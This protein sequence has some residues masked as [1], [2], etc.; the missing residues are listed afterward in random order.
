MKSETF[1][2]MPTTKLSTQ[3]SPPKMSI[4]YSFPWP[5]EK[6]FNEQKK[7]L[8]ITEEEED[9]TFFYDPEYGFGKEPNWKKARAIFYKGEKVRVFPHEFSVLKP[10]NMASYANGDEYCGLQG[11]LTQG[12][13]YHQRNVGWLELDNGYTFFVDREMYEAFCS[14]FEITPVPAVEFK[15][16]QEQSKSESK[17]IAIQKE[18]KVKKPKAKK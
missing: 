17:R 10:E 3:V 7:R 13:D 2:I 15:A 4:H 18:A 1:W 14:L 5:D 9:D 16:P 6:A 12:D 8:H 11:K